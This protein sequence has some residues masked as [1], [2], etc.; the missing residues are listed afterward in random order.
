ML[1]NLYI[2]YAL[3]LLGFWGYA[4]YLARRVSRLEQEVAVLREEEE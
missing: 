4:L 1:T 2:A 3:F